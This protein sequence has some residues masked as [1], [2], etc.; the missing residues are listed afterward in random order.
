MLAFP[1]HCEGFGLPVPEAMRIG[2]PV[3]ASHAC[4]LAEVCGDAALAVDPLDRGDTTRGFQRM[5][6]GDRRLSRLSSAAKEQA[7]RCSP[8]ASAARLAEAYTRLA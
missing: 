6:E 8:D 1:S 2:C 7:A 5:L 3:V 4:G